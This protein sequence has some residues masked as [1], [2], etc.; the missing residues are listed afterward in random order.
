MGRQKKSCHIDVAPVATYFQPRGVSESHLSRVTLELD[1]LE[2]LR[3][4][5]HV[6]LTQTEVAEAM[7]VSRPTVRRKLSS[8]RR[9]LAE[10]MVFGKAIGIAGTDPPTEAEAPAAQPASPRAGR[11]E[12]GY[13]FRCQT[14]SH[15]WSVLP[16]HRPSRFCPYCQ[17]GIIEQL[18]HPALSAAASRRPAE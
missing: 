1:E 4:V 18:N 5:D 8:G 17:H 15:A 11:D 16:G 3:L 12:V 14:C 6:G 10:A 13:A 7:Q 9:K 2:A